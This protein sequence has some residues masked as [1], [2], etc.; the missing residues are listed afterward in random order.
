[1]PE[2]FQ[3]PLNMIVNTPKEDQKKLKRKVNVL[4]A[5]APPPSIIFEKMENLGF[6]VMHV[7]GLTETYGHMLQCVHGMKHGMN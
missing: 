5:G 1:M 3:L 7:Y 6:E 4:T 2:Y